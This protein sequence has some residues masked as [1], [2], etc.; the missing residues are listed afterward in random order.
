MKKSMLLSILLMACLFTQ[1]QTFELAKKDKLEPTEKQ[2]TVDGVLVT[3]FV[4]PSGACY[5]K[6][7]SGTGTIRKIYFG[8]ETAF[9]FNGKPV[10]SDKDQFKYWILG[11]TKSG[12]IKKIEVVKL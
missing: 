7:M 10:F 11:L 8:Y 4:S 12:N 5:Q 1:A 6:V 9:E 3:I 2:I